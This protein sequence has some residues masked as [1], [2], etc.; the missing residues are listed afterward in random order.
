MQHFRVCRCRPGVRTG[1][2]IGKRGN[3]PIG[4]VNDTVR[5]PRPSRLS[6]VIR[7]IFMQQ[8]EK[9]D[10]IGLNKA[11]AL[12]L[13]KRAAETNPTIAFWNVEKTQGD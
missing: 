13:Y 9:R 8:E 6:V 2:T 3:Y 1:T 12:E 7:P 10:V 5:I 11:V 4:I